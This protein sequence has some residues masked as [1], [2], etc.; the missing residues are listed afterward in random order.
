MKAIVYTRYGSPDVLGLTEMETPHP[1]ENEVLVEIHAASVNAGDWHLLR[2]DP[3]MVRFI[4]GLFRPKNR[5]LGVDIAGCVK[6]VG[7]GVTRFVPGDNVFGD[8]SDCGFGA[9]SE[10]VCTPETALVPKPVNL[11]FERAAAAP[12]AAVTALQ[13]L[14]DAGGI[15]VGQTVLVNGAS[16]GVGT[17]AVQIAKYFGAEV[18]GV[19]STRNME[20]VSS[21]GADHVI[22]YQQEDVTRSGRRY[23]LILDTAAF[24]SYADYKTALKTRGVY[25]L[26]GGAGSRFLQMA[27]LGPLISQDSGKRFRTFIKSPRKTDL[28]M[29]KNLLE[30]G[31]ISP[32]MDRRYDL[33]DTS[34]AVRYVE[35]GH[36]RGKVVIGI[37]PAEEESLKLAV[38]L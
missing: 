25:V 23:D 33:A 9:F 36:T 18:T 22:D 35:E 32:V 16:G 6:A 15:Q 31:K 8:L 37:R 29:I 3:V 5:I 21:L 34:A 27:I 26:V 4:Q 38:N 7:S 13:G 19:C 17:F 24:R 28:E 11:S 2:G 10:Y 1:G 12:S 14:R 20:L 30:A